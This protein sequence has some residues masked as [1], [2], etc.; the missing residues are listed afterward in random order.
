MAEY[1]LEH[2]TSQKRR[3]D[4]KKYI[5]RMYKQLS[6]CKKHLNGTYGKKDQ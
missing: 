5:G 1:E 3:H 4:L 6:E 2:A